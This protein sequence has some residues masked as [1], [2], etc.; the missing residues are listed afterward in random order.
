MGQ[1]QGQH[2]SMTREQA[3][4]VGRFER[5]MGSV[6]IAEPMPTPPQTMPEPVTMNV[7]YL[8]SE[9]PMC[10][11]C[12]TGLHPIRQN[13]Q[14]DSLFEC[15]QAGCVGDGYMAV[16]R[17]NPPRWEQFQGRGIVEGWK[18]PMRMA[19]VLEAR[20]KAEAG[21]AAPEPVVPAEQPKGSW[22]DDD[23][24][25]EGKVT[26]S[27]ESKSVQRRKAAQRAARDKS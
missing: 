9:Q 14:G 22:P 5:D 17:V 4:A 3:G 26:V 24:P 8:P 15:V 11:C 18:K 13:A 1:Y 12:Y 23:Q 2:G 7:G 16:Y 20:R 27:T 6:D 25:L 19:D 10:P 21:E